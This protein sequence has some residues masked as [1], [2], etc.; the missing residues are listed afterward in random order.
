MK[1]AILLLTILAVS[2]GEYKTLDGASER[3]GDLRQV[4]GENAAA[5]RL[6][7]E[8]MVQVCNALAIKKSV[9]GTALNSVHTFS[10]SQSDC[11]GNNIGSGNVNVVLQSGLS[12]FVFKRQTDGLDF[13]F[14][15]VET[16]DSGVFADIC[17]DI[18]DLSN[19]VRKEG[20]SDITYFN[21]TSISSSDCSPAS[22]EICVKVEKAFLQ[23]TTAQVH[24][25]EWLRVRV[26]SPDNKYLGFV[27]QR[28]KVTQSFC[29]R[30]EVLTF[31]ASLQI[32]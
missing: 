6:D 29:G 7:R 3:V 31:Q 25:K 14:P 24:T 4:T 13:I 32:K 5:S 23:G 10:T 15:N 16:H 8:N 30:N 17:N 28:K 1:F 9:L 27:T 19:P 20:S 2:C 21:T 22:G 11:E 18:S 26:S 12:G